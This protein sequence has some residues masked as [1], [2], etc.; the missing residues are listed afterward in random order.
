MSEV[1]QS[2]DTTERESGLYGRRGQAQDGID[3]YSREPLALGEAPP[4]RRYSCLQSR[5]TKSV[6]PSELKAS[7]AEFLEGKWCS[8]SRKFIYATAASARS[9]GIVDAVD[10]LATQLAQESVEFVVWGQEEVSRQ[11]KEHA[12]IVDEFFG[13]AWVEEFCG[14]Y[15]AEQL[16]TRLDAQAVAK[17]RQELGR[18]YEASFRVADP[19]FIAFDVRSMK[20][21]PLFQR[22]VTPDLVSTTAQAASSPREL[23]DMWAASGWDPDLPAPFL[24]AAR[25]ST[26]VRD[27][28]N[29]L[30]RHPVRKVH[31]AENTQPTDRR[32]AEEWIGQKPLQ[33]VV[34]DPGAGK[35][36]LLRY[37]VLDL[38]SGDPTWRVAAKRWGQ[39]LPVWLPFHFFTQRVAG[40]T[41][42]EA[43][44]SEALQ[45]WLDQRSASHIWP[46][47]RQALS[48]GRVLLVVDGLDEWV[49]EDAGRAAFAELK[50]FADSRA[51]PVVA[52]TRPYGFSRL[53]L[54]ASW[55]YAR[56]APLTPEQ[57]RQL[58]SNFLRAVADAEDDSLPLGSIGSAVDT[59]MSQLHGA[60]D[61]R[62]LSGTPL[63]LV[64]LL[65][66][67]LSSVTK[68]P[69]GRFQAY[70]RAVQLLVEDHPAQRRIAAAVT[71]S[72]QGLSDQELRRMLARVA[73]E[74][75]RRGDLSVLPE[76]RLQRDFIDALQD[77]D[78]LAKAPS[79]AAETAGQL[80]TVAE[81]ELGL[82]VRKGPQEVGFLHRVLQ[83]QLA[84]EYISTRLSLRE[85]KDLFVQ[86]VGDPQWR[87]VLLATM[88]S[89]H[90]PQELRALTDLIQ[91]KVDETAAGMRARETLAEVLFGPYDLP[92][93]DI[94]QKAPHII[95][96]IETHPYAPHRARLLDSVLKGLEGAAT[97]D[98]VWE[99]LQRWA[100]LVEEPS[101][102][103]VEAIGE[104]PAEASQPELIR[105]LLVRALRYPDTRVAYSAVVAVVRRYSSSG[106]GRGEER[107][108]LRDELFR[109]LSEIPSGL[110]TAAALTAL[111]LE[112]GDDP[113]VVEILRDARGH[114]D[115]NV[116]LVALSH[117]VG[118]LTSVFSNA[119]PVTPHRG[120]PLSSDEREWL[121][122]H[123]RD[124]IYSD[125]HW[126]MLIASV[127]E[128]VQDEPLVL[129]DLL[130]SSNS[131][132]WAPRN[133]FN[134]FDLVWP[135]MLNVYSDDPRVV[136]LVCDQLRSEE[137]SNLTSH[138]TMVDHLLLGRSYPPE[139]P[140]NGAVAAAIEERLR[141][142]P[143]DSFPR[144]L[145]GLAAVDRGP[146][147]KGSLLDRLQSG[148]W[149]HWAA[150]ALAAYFGDDQEVLTALRAKLFGDAVGASMVANTATRLLDPSEVIPHLLAILRRLPESGEPG[151]GRRDIV[152]S[153]L[154][155]AWKEQGVTPGPEL[156]SVAAEALALMPSTPDY[157][158]G[159]PR[160]R[161]AAGLY[162]SSAS[163]AM[164]AALAGNK[165]RPLALYIRTFR[166]E[167]ESLS[168]LL[169]D[170]SAIL[171]AVPP[172]L[173]SRLC[174]AFA[175]GLGTPELVMQVT[176]RWTDEVSHPNAS[177]A[178]LAYHR[179][180][181]T[182]R[183]EGSIDEDRWA[184]AIGHLKEQA[185]LG[186]IIHD[187][188]VR[189]AWVGTCV[190]GD[191][192][193]LKT[194]TVTRVGLSSIVHGPDRTLLLQVAS[195]W[196]D[197]R[198][199]FGED[200]L[201]RLSG[202]VSNQ[203][204]EAWD[205]L[206]L[207]ADRSALLQQ[208]L[209][210]AL[211]ATPGLLRLDGVLAWFVTQGHES[212]AVADVLI[213]RLR[214]GNNR[215]SL[216]SI[217]IDEPE[218]IGLDRDDLVRRLEEGMSP[219]LSTGDP[220][221]Q[222]L[223]GVWPQHPLVLS[224]WNQLRGATGLS[225]F[226]SVRTYFAVAYAGANA[227]EVVDLLKRHLHRL[228]QFDSALVAHAFA[229]YV[230][231]RLRRDTVAANLVR[232]EIMKET[233]PD[234]L[235]ATLVSLLADAVGLSD[236]L[237][238]EVERR[239]TAQRDVDLAPVAQDYTV[240]G[241][242]SVRTVFT[243]AVDAATDIHST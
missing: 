207:V 86:H 146:V 192:S 56:V 209:E 120:G 131:A 24:E 46:L 177:T 127:S 89:I 119:P 1:R 132:G 9:A 161:L 50:V 2:A 186:G 145:A 156:E 148:A 104:L 91:E 92:A 233:T 57:Q 38:L 144:E 41:G 174:D 180:L 152:A 125:V 126:G 206:A 143:M 215:E 235:A 95:E 113:R 33:V 97:D 3:I 218:G 87:E 184:Q 67:H 179:A 59:F 70:D 17:L 203:P 128:A 221:L 232:D 216:A 29:W 66:L 149:P 88:W 212:G 77:P 224:A 173:R 25:W 208:E 73:F 28:E 71:A 116:R 26:G 39:Y 172:Y 121:I 106:L 30:A 210:D 12:K 102:E 42:A 13:R 54:D 112:W 14:D 202:P 15:A 168:P 217:L 19:G 211:A 82:L 76:S 214:S 81:G 142:F 31:R 227:G 183:E 98:I 165:E 84:A 115:G 185:S 204:E 238:R 11:L 74:S 83:E 153:A 10:E 162:P 36:T 110:A 65:G 190:L 23:E 228:E 75:Q 99:C 43:S 237:L 6:T 60:S 134:N 108:F 187:G 133:P 21:V 20:P 63:F 151:V 164:L 195:R 137:H 18:L 64:L 45:A 150:E 100:V 139:S 58:A 27:E 53:S 226:D 109:I 166:Q 68:L 205:A 129:E 222:A 101:Q 200:L 114:G 189:G 230:T 138:M 176:R 103:L 242:H 130:R 49:T 170:A 124:R 72:G 5:R 96:V 181:V 93:T 158:L 123:L 47:V 7:V 234:P 167:P 182:A 157:F 147:M 35:S 32:S 169:R 241:S 117:A 163:K 220:I 193:P 34:G 85:V 62:A 229:R 159:D 154:I 175:E 140:H 231:R 40:R 122:E 90:R 199:E 79:E 61:I 201:E 37:L 141:K 188:S 160:Y 219:H 69:T 4:L 236:D 16:G 94:Q 178:S 22:F 155:E 191:W 194:P 105:K 107:D 196:E 213:S 243:R 55:A 225:D 240:F 51:V 52:S 135:V 111:A 223:A 8:V 198:T 136:E 78:D 118:V 44:V 171:F 239:I 197:L 80:L 48:D